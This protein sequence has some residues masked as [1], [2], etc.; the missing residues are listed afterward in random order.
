MPKPTISPL[1]SF[2][3]SQGLSPDEFADLLGI[4][5]PTLR[6]LENGT[7][8]ITAERAKQIEEKTRGGLTRIDLRPDLFGA[9]LGY[10]RRRTEATA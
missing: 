3:E 9:V 8:P 1:R 2:R 5:R 4:P 10:R 7:R 6:S